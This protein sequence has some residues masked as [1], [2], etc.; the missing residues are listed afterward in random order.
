MKESRE[1]G[2]AMVEFAIV[3]PILLALVL[4][5]VEFGFRYQRAAFLNNAAYIAARDFSIHGNYS[6]A[7]AAATAANNG[8]VPPGFPGSLPGC[9]TVPVPGVTTNVSII[10]NS[11]APS[12]TKMFG[13][14]FV[15]RVKGAAR[16]ES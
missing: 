3:V 5:L 16:C 14:T 13:S 8:V 6:Q 7:R 10:F 4:G 1:R 15:V 11:T 12:K 9:P 2:A